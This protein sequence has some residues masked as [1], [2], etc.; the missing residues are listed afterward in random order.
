MCFVSRVSIADACPN[1]YVLAI[2]ADGVDGDAVVL[3]M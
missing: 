1:L 2:F 3:T